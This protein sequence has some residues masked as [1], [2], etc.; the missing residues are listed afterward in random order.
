MTDTE[1]RRVW[2]TVQKRTYT[3]ARVFSCVA[4][5]YENGNDEFDTRRAG[6]VM[7]VIWPQNA[8]LGGSVPSEIRGKSANQ[9]NNR[10][11][12]ADFIRLAQYLGADMRPSGGRSDVGQVAQEADVG[13]ASNQ[14]SV[15]PAASDLNAPP[16]ARVAT[17][18]S[19]IVR[20]TDLAN[21]VKEQHNRLCQLCGETVRLADGS[22][23][24]EGHHL[25]PLGSPHDGPDVAE[26]I[27]CLCPNHHAA[28]DL[29]AIR[30]VATDLRSA[31]RHAVGQKFL[32]YHNRRSVP[33]RRHLTPN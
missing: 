1:I 10:N 19:R 32:N 28:C 24:A 7:R 14:R 18:V 13:G 5:A 8:V 2:N 27:V 26:N 6:A 16:A 25:Q 30:L 4:S 15:P 23:Y 31:D 11:R 20:D 3:E 21:W 29:G 22:G 12:Q 17:T 33:R 9:N